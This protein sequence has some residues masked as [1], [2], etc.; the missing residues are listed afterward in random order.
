VGVSRGDILLGIDDNQFGD[1]TADFARETLRTACTIAAEACQRGNDG[2][3]TLLV[4]KRSEETDHVFH[5]IMAMRDDVSS[6]RG[7]GSSLSSMTVGR[8]ASMSPRSILE[9]SENHGR[10]TPTFCTPGRKTPSFHTPE[11]FHS[12][13]NSCHSPP[14]PPPPNDSPQSI[15]KQRS[16]D[17]S[18]DQSIYSFHLQTSNGHFPQIPMQRNMDFKSMSFP[19]RYQQS[20]QRRPLDKHDQVQEFKHVSGNQW[21]LQSSQ[22]RPV[23]VLSTFPPDPTIGA[24][25][26]SKVVP[27]LQRLGVFITDSDVYALMAE[28]DNQDAFIGRNKSYV[29]A[30][31][32]FNAARKVLHQNVGEN[33]ITKQNRDNWT[34]KSLDR[35][36]IHKQGRNDYQRS[37]Q[38]QRRDGHGGRRNEQKNSAND[39]YWL[40]DDRVHSPKGSDVS[41]SSVKDVRVMSHLLAATR[42]ERDA[43]KREAHTWMA[44][45]EEAQ[46]NLDKANRQ[47]EE[48][49]IKAKVS[50]AE[51]KELKI[52][53][54]ETLDELDQRQMDEGKKMEEMKKISEERMIMKEELES[55]KDHPEVAKKTVFQTSLL[56][57]FRPF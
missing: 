43:S 5:S 37:H 21:T 6:L 26:V 44:R 51:N 39:L 54:R 36:L 48:A 20:R 12:P 16:R 31:S 35:H 7:G 8:A 38:D 41:A 13:E 30:E 52:Q 50:S 45:A 10:Q 4:K 25:P 46:L 17:D 24:I 27:A 22:T 47:L 2:H 28:L 3:M 14:P 55:R 57:Y 40:N 33:E 18:D 56:H 9:D 19:R 42:K 11:S 32:C 53:L 29:D 1:V 49:K 34:T 15:R 23:D